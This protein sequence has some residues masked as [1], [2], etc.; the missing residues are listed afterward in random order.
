MI[1]DLRPLFALIIK[2]MMYFNKLQSMVINARIPKTFKM[3]LKWTLGSSASM[4]QVLN[5]AH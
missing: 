5:T 1:D 2:Y 3:V 4:L